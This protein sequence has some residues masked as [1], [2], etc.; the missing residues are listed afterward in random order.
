[1]ADV[2]GEYIDFPLRLRTADLLNL[3]RDINTHHLVH[4]QI[5]QSLN[6]FLTKGILSNG[7]VPTIGNVDDAPANPVGVTV[8]VAAALAAAAL[9]CA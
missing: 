1:M 6:I 7:K 2:I 9:F 3:Q 4:N 8:Q 5:F